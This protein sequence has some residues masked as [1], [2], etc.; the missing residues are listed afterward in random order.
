MPAFLETLKNLTVG[1]VHVATA[2]GNVSTAY[3]QDDVDDDE[4]MTPEQMRK[5]NPKKKSDARTFLQAIGNASIEDYSDDP[6]MSRKIADE[7]HEF[8]LSFDVTKIDND[9]RQIFGWASIASIDGVAVIDKQDDIIPIDEL[10]K[11]AHDFTLYSRQ[12]GHMHEDIGTGRLIESMVHNAEKRKCGVVA[13]DEQGRT[14][15]GWWV[16]FQIDDADQWTR[17]KA[18]ERPEFSIGG[19]S[20]WEHI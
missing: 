12:M 18:N 20:S 16:G 4:S 2:L 9:K 14:I 6:I 8:E 3:T 10:E 19:R 17:C 5:P 1:D 15:D 7:M 11:A 13:K